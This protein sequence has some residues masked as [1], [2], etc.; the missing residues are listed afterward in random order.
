MYITVLGKCALHFKKIG[1]PLSSF[2]VALHHH[3]VHSS[4]NRA[5]TKNRKKSRNKKQ[6]LNVCLY[7]KAFG[8]QN[9]YKEECKADN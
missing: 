1:L 4:A 2:F 5:S 6:T 8:R 9:S 3:L 7:D